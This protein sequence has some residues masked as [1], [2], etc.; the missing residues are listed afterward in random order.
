MCTRIHGKS[1][2]DGASYERVQVT[3]L[4]KSQDDDEED[5]EDKGMPSD[6]VSQ[7]KL[8]R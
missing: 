4:L 6:D 3:D 7:H 1:E 5:H 2:R 8:S